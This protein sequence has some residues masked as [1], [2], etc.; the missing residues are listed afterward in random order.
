MSLRLSATPANASKRMK[1]LNW[2]S[3]PRLRLANATLLL[4]TQLYFTTDVVAK[5]YLLNTQ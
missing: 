2:F 3:A 1:K 5:T 4:Y